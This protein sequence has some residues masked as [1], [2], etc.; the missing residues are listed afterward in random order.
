[1]FLHGYTPPQIMATTRHISERS[2]RMYLDA[3]AVTAGE[4]ALKLTPRNA[5]IER[6]MHTVP[7]KL[8]SALPWI[9]DDK[10]V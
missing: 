6:L 2:F 4:V 8:H 1:M 7:H 10:R 3:T 9:R 5:E